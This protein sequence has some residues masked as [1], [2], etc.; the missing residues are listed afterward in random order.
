MRAVVVLRVKGI[1]CVPQIR[2]VRR[3]I[4]RPDD[5]QSLVDVGYGLSAVSVGASVVDVVKQINDSS[6]SVAS[7]VWIAPDG[8]GLQGEILMLLL[9]LSLMYQFD[10]H[11]WGM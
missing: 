2:K 4:G 3:I 10:S 9:F 1:H 7:S 5:G 11:L 6:K 8:V